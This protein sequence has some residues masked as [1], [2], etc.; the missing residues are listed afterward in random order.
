MLHH[1]FPKALAPYPVNYDKRVLDACVL[2]QFTAIFKLTSGSDVL[3]VA[4][5]LDVIGYPSSIPEYQLDNPKSH[6]RRCLDIGCGSGLVST[7]SRF[8]AGIDAQC[9]PKVLG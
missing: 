9:I 8:F 1:A 2:S 3:D 4:F 5:R 6:P 7:V